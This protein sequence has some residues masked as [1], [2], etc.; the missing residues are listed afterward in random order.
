MVSV[1]AYFSIGSVTGCAFNSWIRDVIPEKVLGRFLAKRLAVAMG[2]AVGIGLLAAF[3]I[4][5]V[6]DHDLNELGAYSVLFAV[7]AAAGLIG[8]SYLAMIPEPTMAPPAHDNLFSVLKQPF[9]D[10]NFR[11]LLIFLA[12]WNFAVNFSAP[13][14]AV[15]MLKRI[16]VSMSVVL[17]LMILSQVMNVVSFRIWGRLAD[18]FSHK[19]VLAV[20]GPIYL[21]SVLLWPFTTM[22]DAHA[23][24]V[25]LLVLIH[26]LAG[27]SLSG[28][29]L[30]SGGIALKAAPRGTA[31]AYL[32]TNSLI[33]GGAATL[34]PIVAGLAADGFETQHISVNLQWISELGQHH[35]MAMPALNLGGLDFLFVATI[36]FGLYSV[37]RLSAVEERGEVKESIILME[38]H[39]EIRSIVRSMSTVAGLR[40]LTYFPYMRLRKMIHRRFL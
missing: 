40:N 11:K 27:L 22:P 10:K 17:I 6:K 19:S 36:I 1:F 7:G 8:A 23:F 4:D 20:S 21:I 9:Q 3:G 25:P 14:F 26:A 16:G 29:T 35:E 38:L 33:S 30:C 32:A 31:T 24:T 13:F 2:V 34:A 12:T 5:Y 37:H 28:V 15:Y 39:G 18:R